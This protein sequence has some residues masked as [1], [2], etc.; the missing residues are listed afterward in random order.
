MG[1]AVLG[2]A[3]GA[4]G[5]LVLVAL[6]AL[7]LAAL[8]RRRPS[9]DERD[10]AAQDTRAAAPQEPAPPRPPAAESPAALAADLPPI[11]RAIWE[12]LRRGE[13]ML[14]PTAIVSEQKQHLVMAALV[15]AHERWNADGTRTPCL[16]GVEELCVLHPRTPANLQKGALGIHEDTAIKLLAHLRRHLLRF[17]AVPPGPTNRSGQGFATRLPCDPGQRALAL[18]PPATHERPVRAPRGSGRRARDPQIQGS[19]IEFAGSIAGST[20]PQSGS[21]GSPDQDAPIAGSGDPAPP[22]TPPVRRSV[23]SGSDP[24]NL[25]TSATTR[26][27]DTGAGPVGLPEEATRGGGATV[28]VLHAWPPGA[29]FQ[30]W[31]PHLEVPGGKRTL[32]RRV[33]AL[34]VEGPV[35]EEL[36]GV[37]LTHKQLK[38]YCAECLVRTVRVMRAQYGQQLH[39]VKS[40]P[41]TADRYLDAERNLRPWVVTKPKSGPPA[42]RAAPSGPAPAAEVAREVDAAPAGTDEAAALWAQALPLVCEGQ[43]AP[44]VTIW[45]D[46]LRCLRLDG[47]GV[48]L[49]AP[50]EF[51]AKWVQEHHGQRILSALAAVLGEPV[52][53]TW[54]HG[55]RD[56]GAHEVA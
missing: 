2:A 47:G 39:G 46:P 48:R 12:S 25:P 14:L 38:T 49:W 35:P 23:L 42:V 19:D 51:F 40:E 16:L 22:H 29:C 56:E 7:V 10:G 11:V 8:R 1:S 41:A 3:A 15:A 43:S 9:P 55:P 6:G 21:A 24:Q 13:A 17:C 20:D 28:E 54:E 53:I 18:P 31:T 27:P 26:S 5:A 34:G 37:P 50:N 30:C 33:P 52:T 45:F 36:R 32:S 44:N 4:G